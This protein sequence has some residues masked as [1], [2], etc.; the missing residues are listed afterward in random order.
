MVGNYYANFREIITTKQNFTANIA[1]KQKL[2]AK[3]IGE[4][5]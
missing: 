1:S 3:Q 5:A 2:Q 4:T